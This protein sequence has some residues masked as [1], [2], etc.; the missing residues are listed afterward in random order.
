VPTSARPS[1]AELRIRILSVLEHAFAERQAVVEV[2]AAA[3]DRRAAV[4]ALQDRFGWDDVSATAVLEIKI[5]DW[6]AKGR[7]RTAADLAEAE[8][9]LA[10]GS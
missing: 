7:A 2:V 6:T 5:Q 8:R 9:A 4:A 1:T 3:A 10:A